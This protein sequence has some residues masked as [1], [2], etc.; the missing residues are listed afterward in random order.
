MYVGRVFFMFVCSK[1]KRSASRSFLSLKLLTF[2]SK[3]VF[4]RVFVG[5]FFFFFLR[6][7]ISSKNIL[8]QRLEKTNLLLSYVSARKNILLKGQLLTFSSIS[9]LF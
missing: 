1:R 5:F 7:N 2:D 4:Y 3:C 6:F 8:S 9:S